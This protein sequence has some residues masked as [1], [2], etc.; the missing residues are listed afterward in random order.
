[1]RH[2]NEQKGP[3]GSDQ[4]MGRKSAECG[5]LDTQVQKVYQWTGR[6]I[7]KYLWLKCVGNLKS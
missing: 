2:P 1:M 3:T 5:I 4:E 7:L 6:T